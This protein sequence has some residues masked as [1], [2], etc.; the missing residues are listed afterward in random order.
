MAITHLMTN[1]HSP[2]SRQE[3]EMEER[4]RFEDIQNKIA[5]D[6]LPT[7]YSLLFAYM[8]DKK[9]QQS[10]IDSELDDKWD[11]LLWYVEDLAEDEDTHEGVK[12]VAKEML[13]AS[14]DDYFGMLAL[15]RGSMKVARFDSSALV[16]KLNGIADELSRMQQASQA[17]LER[18]VDLEW[19]EHRP[20]LEL[21]PIVLFGSLLEIT[22]EGFSGLLD[23]YWTLKPEHHDLLLSIDVVEML[24]FDG[25]DEQLYPN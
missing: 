19:N 12:N 1:N 6:H 24:R 22:H 25:I 13:K 20:A 16:D 3:L 5:Q 15:L 9:E 7:A 8:M 2:K 17:W 21:Q 11:Q 4:L 18:N 10:F 14:C 23:N